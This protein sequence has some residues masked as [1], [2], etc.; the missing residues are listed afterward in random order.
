M[1]QKQLK[2][3]T[4]FNLFTQREITHSTKTI[5]ESDIF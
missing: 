2:I 3:V 5:K 1:E 4:Y